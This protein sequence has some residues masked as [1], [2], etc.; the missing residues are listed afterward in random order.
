MTYDIKETN[1]QQPCTSIMFAWVKV[2]IGKVVFKGR[3]IAMA[4]EIQPH[5]VFLFL[6][7]TSGMM[8]GTGGQT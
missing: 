1:K 7:G 2:V 4:E 3:D 5:R 6:L 8:A